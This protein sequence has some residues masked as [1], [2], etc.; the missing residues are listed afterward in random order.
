MK[1]IHGDSHVELE[2]IK[3]ES[4]DAIIIDPPYRYFKK[5]K[6]FRLDKSFDREKIFNELQRVLK[7]KS[8]ICI[9]GR[10]VE[11]C[12]DVIYLQKLGFNFL[13]EI[14]W[15]KNRGS[16][17]F[18]EM[19]RYHELC[20]ILA[21]G[22]RKLNKIRVD[23][24]E[25]IESEERLDKLKM[26]YQRIRSA[27]NNKN[28]NDLKTYIE[29]GI[30]N[31]KTDYHSN[32]RIVSDLKKIGDAGVNTAKKINEGTLI[33]S[34]IK[35]NIEQNKYKVPTQKPVELLKRLILLTTKEGDLILD[36]FMGS[37]S[38]GKAALDLN[39]DFVGIEI[40]DEYFNIAKE[41]I[42][43]KQRELKEKLNLKD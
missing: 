41:N 32:H 33:R 25:T 15:Y 38:C 36:C 9:F 24:F 27:L 5:E 39:R 17:M 12:K 23:Y 2:K 34:V 20:F 11:L 6:K 43:E 7:K 26:D 28:I 18:G 37:A 22:N 31:Y 35:C 14:V 13:E 42:E 1:L 40:D 3:S 21:K 4:I 29:S 10:G 19:L 8:C 16:N 30:I